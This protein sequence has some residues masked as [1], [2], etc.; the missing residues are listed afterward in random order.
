MIPSPVIITPR[1]LP[2]LKIGDS[3]LSVEP[4][5]A[6]G[7]GKPRWRW[8]LDTPTAEHSGDDLRGWGD[9]GEML[10][11]LCSFLVACAESRHYSRSTGRTGGNADLFNDAVGEWAEQYSDEISLAGLEIEES[12]RG[13]E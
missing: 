8:H 4:I 9:A 13:E 6:V 2:G 10:A 3:F 7:S 1:L 12:G 5:L 11:A